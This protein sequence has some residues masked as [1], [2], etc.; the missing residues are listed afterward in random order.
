MVARHELRAYSTPEAGIPSEHLPT[1]REAALR[2][3]DD[4]LAPAA[5]E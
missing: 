2:K 3:F 5:V 4:V 1:R